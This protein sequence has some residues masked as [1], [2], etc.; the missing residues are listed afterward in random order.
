MVS[1]ETRERVRRREARASVFSAHSL[2]LARRDVS[3]LEGVYLE[4]DQSNQ[5]TS[6]YKNVALD[7]IYMKSISVEHFDNFLARKIISKVAY[8]MD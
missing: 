1:D 8:P 2:F 5:K 3:K 7:L 4:I 6:N